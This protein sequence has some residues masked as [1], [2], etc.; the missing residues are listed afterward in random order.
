M[1]VSREHAA[2]LVSGT[3]IDIE[4]PGGRLTQKTDIRER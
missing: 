3:A 2:L 1:I 4:Q